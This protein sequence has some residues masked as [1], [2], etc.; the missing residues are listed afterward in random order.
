MDRLAAP[1]I[2]QSVPALVSDARLRVGLADELM[3]RR[4]NRWPIVGAL[5]V[6]LDPLIAA[7]R[8]RLPGGLSRPAALEGLVAAHLDAGHRPLSARVQSA[9][10]HLQQSV[11]DVSGLYESRR[12]WEPMHADAAV[13]ELQRTLAEALDHQREFMRRR[14][15]RSW[16]PPG[17]LSRTSLTIGAAVWFPI[18]QPMLD[19]WL[20]S[21]RDASLLVVAVSVLSASHLLRSAAFLAIYFLFIWLVLQWHSRRKVDRWLERWQLSDP[22]EADE[23]LVARVIGWIE[24]LLNPIRR[25]G[26]RL[27]ELIDRATRI[28]RASLPD[29]VDQ[30]ANHPG[31]GQ[32]PGV[33]RG[34]IVS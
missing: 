17:W 34:E 28:R 22:L 12:L 8:G 1:I 14:L 11:P 3:Q 16:G 33:P 13:A 5:H 10:A 30:S 27:G 31:A 9:F 21:G 2:E 26:E 19:A 23:N 6:L 25:Q 32:E 20:A 29:R 18:V 24:S 7:L 15:D 4:V